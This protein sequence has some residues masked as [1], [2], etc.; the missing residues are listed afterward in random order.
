MSKAEP[1][2]VSGPDKKPA[3]NSALIVLDTPTYTWIFVLLFLSAVT[4]SI[5]VP[6]LSVFA[7]ESLGASVIQVSSYFATTAAT[8]MVVV[9]VV[10]KVSDSKY[11]RKSFIVFSYGSLALGYSLLSISQQFVHMILIGVVL[12]SSMSVGS[13]QLFA[14]AKNVTDELGFNESEASI[15]S[16]LRMAYSLGWVVGPALGGGLLSYFDARGI[17]RFSSLFAAV[18]IAFSVAFLPSRPVTAN[19]DQANNVRSFLRTHN[20]QLLIFSASIVFLLSGDI[21][22]ISLLPLHVTESLYVSPKE[23]GLV[24]AVTPLMEV[25]AIPLAGIL[26]DKIGPGRVVASGAVAGS[27]YYF[28]LAASPS[29]GVI[30]ALQALYAYVVAAI[31]GVGISYSQRLGNGQTGTATGAY[32]SAQNAS[33]ILGSFLAGFIAQH[34]G[35]RFSFVLPAVSCLIGLILVLKVNRSVDERTV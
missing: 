22:R 13:S 15:T 26:A 31:V 20:T 12:L 19:Q 34:L 1:S 3:L 6:V 24:F 9:L 18:I 8:G 2:T 5:V 17:F 33:A 23:L 14:L 27:I 10:G 16:F 7:V 21:A 35:Y 32:F 11:S 29:I 25:I 4:S 30:Y 28:G